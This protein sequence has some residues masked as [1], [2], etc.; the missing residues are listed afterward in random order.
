LDITANGGFSVFNPEILTL[1][2]KA[3]LNTIAISAFAIVIGFSLGIGAG[4]ARVSKNPLVRLPATAYVYVIR[5]TPLLVQLFLWFFGL[6]IVSGG[7]L[8]LEPI[9][10]AIIA[11][12]VHSG[13]YQ[14][15]IIRGGVNS[16]PKGQMEAARA[17]GMNQR[18]SMRYVVLPQALRLSL[19]P[20]ANEFVIV[21]KDSSLAYA[22]SVA[23]ITFVSYQL[24]GKYFEPFQIFLFAAFLYFCLTLVTGYLM[25]GVE[26]KYRIPGYGEH[27]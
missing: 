23:E 5:G 12:G 16:I 9:Y 18:Q 3:T 8:A 10:A 13:A 2:F 17:T 27:E 24:N 26:K 19:P 1:Y 11:V 15:E 25:R 7:A 22:V 14:A 21:I 6:A 20:L 4:L